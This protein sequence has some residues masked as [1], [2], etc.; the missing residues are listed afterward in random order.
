M[1]K[2]NTAAPHTMRAAG[3]DGSTPVFNSVATCQPSCLRILLNN[4]APPDGT[5]P[6]DDGVLRYAIRISLDSSVKTLIRQ[7]S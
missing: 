5:G 6:S 1:G 3:R 7:G 2:N 4:K